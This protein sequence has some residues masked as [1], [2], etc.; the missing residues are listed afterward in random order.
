MSAEDEFQFR[1]CGSKHPADVIK[2]GMQELLGNKFPES[3]NMP[4]FSADA[5]FEP[6]NVLRIVSAST[7]N[8]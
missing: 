2:N 6:Q 4:F 5:L 3:P 7:S 8:S 1:F